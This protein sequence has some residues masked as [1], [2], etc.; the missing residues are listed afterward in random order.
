MDKKDLDSIKNMDK[1]EAINILKENG[2]DKVDIDGVHY[3]ETYRGDFYISR[4]LEGDLEGIIARTEISL[5]RYVRILK[6]VI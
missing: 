6:E 2:W 4:E 5:E 1:K 3:L